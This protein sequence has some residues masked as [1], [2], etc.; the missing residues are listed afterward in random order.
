MTSLADLAALSAIART[1]GFAP[2]SAMPVPWTGGTGQVF[3]CGDVVI[4][5]PFDLPSEIQSV[6]VDA[7]VV[8]I[9][10][11]LGVL[12]PALVA[13]DD[14]LAILPVPFAVFERVHGAVT[15]DVRRDAGRS[16]EEGWEEAG[17]QIAR[18]HG[19]RDPAEVPSPLRTFRQSPE[20]DPRP[21]VTEFHEAG[22]LDES[23]ARWLHDLLDTLAP[24]A[25]AD[26][27]LALCHG[28]VN[29]T[30]VL[31]DEV[32]G[33]FR[34]LIDWAGAGWLDPAWDFAGVSLDIVPAML[35]GHRSVAP[36]MGDGAAEARICWCQ[37]QTRLH[38]HRDVPTNAATREAL[39]R[40]LEQVRRFARIAELA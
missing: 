23:D 38:A 4:K 13:F 9:A 40:H 18:V 21:W 33:R 29:A 11:S 1:H 15:L 5:I 39:G 31:I 16:V 20:V 6:T 30:N 19:V 28:D 32:S 27:P 26:V 12:A 8:P 25:L 14:S 37:V 10:R 7:G 24:D 22:V 17:R 36:L 3:P 35:A 2:P 34:A